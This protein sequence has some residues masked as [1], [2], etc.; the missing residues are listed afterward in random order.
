MLLNDSCWA[1]ATEFHS[2]CRLYIL[3]HL[4]DEEALYGAADSGDVS[5]VRQLIARH[6]NVNSKSPQVC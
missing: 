2:T 6:V 5:A 1:K 4:Q 3:V